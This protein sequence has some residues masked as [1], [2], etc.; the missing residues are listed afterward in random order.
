MRNNGLM[1]RRC[2]R[3]VIALN[4]NRLTTDFVFIF[5]AEIRMSVFWS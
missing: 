1:I 4:A 5:M 3:D 2:W